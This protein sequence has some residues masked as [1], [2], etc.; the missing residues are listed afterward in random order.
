M[1]ELRHLFALMIGSHRKYVDPSKAVEI[2]KEAF[3]NVPS[4]PGAF[5]SQQVTWGSRGSQL[6]GHVTFCLPERHIFI[7]SDVINLS[8]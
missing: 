6:V 5:D 4:N 7:N 3:R 8:I 1:K 2:L